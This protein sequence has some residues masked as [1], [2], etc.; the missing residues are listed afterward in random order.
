M[1]SGIKKILGVLLVFLSENWVFVKKATRGVMGNFQ[2]FIR[3]KDK[4]GKLHSY[5]VTYRDFKILPEQ[6]EEIQKIIN[7]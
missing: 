7:S 6:W 3:F 2:K 4:H 5:F 1:R